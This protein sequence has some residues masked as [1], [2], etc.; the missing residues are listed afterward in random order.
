[1][2]INVKKVT[3]RRK[4]H[5][6]TL[7]EFLDDAERLGKGAVHTL[8]NKSYSQILHH[9]AFAINGS[10]DG[11][12]LVLPWPI[13][14]VARLL[15]KRI[16]NGGMSPGFKLSRRNEVKA[17]TENDDD[18]P[19]ALEAVRQAVRRFQ[20]ETKRSPHPAFGRLTPD[21]WYTFHLRHSE[22]H[23]SFVVPA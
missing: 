13:R 17:W 16:L 11:S 8:G 22:L 12:V 3:N 2:T 6:N 9:L 5:Y 4:V 18:I 7:Q 1:M 14:T 19:A 15:R 20:T 10:V 23:M 21:E